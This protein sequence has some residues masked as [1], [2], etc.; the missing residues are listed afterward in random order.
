M[1]KS[2]LVLPD[3]PT[4]SD[5]EYGDKGCEAKQAALHDWYDPDRRKLPPGDGFRIVPISISANRLWCESAYESPSS[6]GR[7]TRPRSPA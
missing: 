3:N 6:R 2:R 7:S 4:A 1:A 5:A